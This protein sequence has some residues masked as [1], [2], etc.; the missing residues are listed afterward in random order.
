MNEGKKNIIL[1]DYDVD[2]DKWKFK[3]ILESVT[4]DRWVVKRHVTNHLHGGLLPNL[5]RFFW[6]FF[7]P[8]IILIRRKQY[9]KVIGWQQF[10][11]LNFA[12]W[13]RFLG[14]KK[15]NDL[16]VM[17]FIYKKKGGLKGK[18]YH[19]YM[20]YIVTSKY[21]DRFICFAKEEC[22]YYSDIFGIDESKFIYVPLGHPMVTDIQIADDGYI[23]S[24]G[25]SNRDYDFL[26]N[27]LKNTNFK[28]IIACDTYY[29]S[30]GNAENIN[31]L[32]KC[33]GNDMLSLMAKCHCV[34]VPLKNLKMSSGQLVVLQAMSLGKPVICTDADGIRDYVINGS[35]GFLIDNIEEQLLTILNEL[36]VDANKYTEL[37][38]NSKECYLSH[39]TEDA[40]Y[41]RIANKL[42]C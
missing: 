23:F 34:V 13:S 39:F 10:Y 5:L 38:N 14:L 17:T 40:M 2:N 29:A 12:F 22:H 28:L 4:R 41:E 6:Y 36:Y 8:L 7:F 42:K 33:H 37:S 26:V 24:T 27:S 15:V 20:S 31:V 11:G 1:V 21:I 9:D 18:L 30:H 3:K 32:N 19:K 35:T 16:T 25:R